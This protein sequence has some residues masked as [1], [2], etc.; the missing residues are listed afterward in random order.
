LSLE[1]HRLKKKILKQSIAKKED[2]KRA[3]PW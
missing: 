1:Q 3:L 2:F